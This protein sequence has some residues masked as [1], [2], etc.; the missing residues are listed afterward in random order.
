MQRLTL[1]PDG[2]L[3]GPDGQPFQ[4]QQVDA[5]LIDVAHLA[6]HVARD[7][8]RPPHIRRRELFSVKH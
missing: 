4:G 6:A 3:L 2:P 1:H 7:T 8:F 5:R